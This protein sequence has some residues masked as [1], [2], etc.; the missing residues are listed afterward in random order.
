MCQ[1]RDLRKP[2]V[3]SASIAGARRSVCMACSPDPIDEGARPPP[4]TSASLSCP[5]G[6]PVLCRFSRGSCVRPVQKMR[7]HLFI[8]R[9]TRR[10]PATCELRHSA[11]EDNA[12]PTSQVAVPAN[13]AQSPPGSFRGSRCLWPGFLQLVLVLHLVEDDCALLT[14]LRLVACS[15]G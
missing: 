3:R 7:G 8:G 13:E 14:T 1:N 10:P 5:R 4:T 6:A 2:L 15:Y 9:L 11:N 12:Q